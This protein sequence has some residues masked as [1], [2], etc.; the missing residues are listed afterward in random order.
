MRYFSQKYHN[1]S[2]Y[3]QNNIEMITLTSHS[4]E[5]DEKKSKIRWTVKLNFMKLTYQTHEENG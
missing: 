4:R 2:F 3:R 1:R 5:S